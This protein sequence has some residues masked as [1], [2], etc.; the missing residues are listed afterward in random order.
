MCGKDTTVLVLIP[1]SWS[2]PVTDVVNFSSD[3]IG[4][5]DE[6]RAQIQMNYDAAGPTVSLDEAR[7]IEEESAKRLLASRKLILIVDLDQT[8]V[9]AT[10]DP[11]VGEWMA[12]GQAYEE[13]KASRDAKS[14]ER[15]SK[16]KPPKAA[17]GDEDGDNSDA[18]STDSDDENEAA[19]E[20][21][22]NWAMLKDV[23]RFKLGPELPAAP[24]RPGK[25]AQPPQDDG[26]DYYI[27]P[28]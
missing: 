10:V 2:P 19:V 13:K 26:C 28:R 27:K 3:Y 24:S 14:K 7:R 18:S 22:P 4:T 15:K 25:P 6:N 23:A 20:V 5:S 1:C 16:P 8:I 12:Q 21:N 17:N 11:T 9:H